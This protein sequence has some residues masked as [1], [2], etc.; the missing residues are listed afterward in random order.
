MNVEQRFEKC[1]QWNMSGGINEF[2]LR[3]TS[4]LKRKFRA[5]TQKVSDELAAH[6]RAETDKLNGELSN[7]IQDD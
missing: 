7:E 3:I 4:Q 2:V 1:R 6:F 5:E